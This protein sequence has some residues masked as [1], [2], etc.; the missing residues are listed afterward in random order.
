MSLLLL[1][2]PRNTSTPAIP[3][4]THDGGYRYI[5]QWEND[6][7]YQEL[8]K[9]A[10][11]RKVK[12]KGLRK[13]KLANLDDKHKEQVQKLV[14]KTGFSSAW[15][16]TSN[17]DETLSL[18]RKYI[19]SLEAQVKEAALD[20]YLKQL[21]VSETR[22]VAAAKER[23]RLEEE[24]NQTIALIQIVNETK[25]LYAAQLQQEDDLLLITII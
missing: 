20:A 5:G 2:R 22:R 21:A 24:I 1:L 11:K 18:L 25:A 3:V 4:D 15:Q 17:A 19:L 14:T 7:E 9:Q 16:V 13:R 8:R 10:L 6:P 12:A 23:A